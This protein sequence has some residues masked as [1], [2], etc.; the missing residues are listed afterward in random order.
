ML[1]DNVKKGVERAPHR[2]LFWAMGYH[3]EEME[4]PLIGIVNSASEIVPGHIH[5]PLIAEAVKTGVR[6]AGGT[7]VEFSTIAVCDGIAMNHR[8]MHYSL[9]SRELIADSIETMAEAHCFDALV[10]ITNCDK[11]IPG[12]LMS[13]LRLNIPSLI[14]SGG[15]MMAGEYKNNKVDLSTVFEA[16][17]SVNSGKMTVEELDE[18][19]AKAC[20][21]CG[22][23]AGM[24]TANTMNCLAEALGLAVP[25]NGTVPAVSADRIRIAKESGILVMRNLEKARLPRHIACPAAFKNALAVDMALGG[26]TNTV[27]HLP[28]IAAEAGI[29]LDLNLIN[30]VSGRTPQLCC[31]SPAGEDRIQ[32]LDRAG[33]VQAVMKELARGSLLDVSVPTVNSESLK[34]TI[35]RAASPDGNVI[36]RLEEPY[37]PDGGLAIL[38]GNLAPDGA[39]VKQGA[40]APE[41]LV[42]EGVARVFNSEEEAVKAISGGKI[43]PGDVVVIRYEGPRGGPGMREMLAPTST[44]AG[45]GL[46]KEVA[47]ITDGR[48]SG[49]TKGASI[50][51]VS[52]EAA[53]GGP[54]A[55]VRDGDRIIIDIPNRR[56]EI[57]VSDEEIKARLQTVVEPHPKV[58]HGYLRRYRRM[59]TSANRGAILETGSK[60]E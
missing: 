31:L 11:V 7:P 15:P 3:P 35:D 22:S 25:G 1:S 10:C 32:D 59:V 46:D 24:F 41:M 50:G 20:P 52:P 58:D 43:S 55:A 34:D 54:I 36:R 21:G 56:L 16:V 30:Q 49:A 8:G 4:R 13:M 45:M 17:G 42:S 57:R 38:F 40:V 51:H 27:L 33:G 14:V 29:T 19:T 2:S 5:L 18:L 37:R 53:A 47:L 12:M 28:A 26:S 48:F 6:L 9:A 44:I 23:C 39:V 60:Q